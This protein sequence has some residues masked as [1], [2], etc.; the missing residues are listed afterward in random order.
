[1]PP[2]EAQRYRFAGFEVDVA[3]RELRRNGRRIPLQPQPF[4]LL[5]LLLENAG[6]VVTRE[7]IAERLWKDYQV[8]DPAQSLNVAVGKLRD[9]LNDRSAEPAF[10]ETVSKYGYR[11]LVAVDTDNATPAQ[12]AAPAEPV[13]R[14]RW[15]W[16]AAAAAAIVA[17]AAV[18]LLV[19]QPSVPDSPAPVIV[20]RFEDSTGEKDLEGAY[21][22]FLE[23]ELASSRFVSVASPDR[24]GDVL[25]LM[26]KDPSGRP[27]FEDAIEVCRRDPAIRAV[28]GGELR[29]AGA[30]YWLSLRLVNPASA[31]SMAALN[32]EA[33]ARPGLA[34]VLR[35]FSDAIRRRM[36]ESPPAQTV[37]L[38]KV[39]TRSLQAL[40]LFSDAH[41]LARSWNWRT[42]EVLFRQAADLDPE[43]A[44]AHLFVAWAI[45]NQKD[46]SAK[47]DYLP[48]AER[49]LALAANASEQEALF[50]RGSYYSLQLDQRSLEQSVPLYDL[51]LRRYPDHPWAFRNLSTTYSFL[52]QF[53]NRRVLQRSLLQL[54]PH[55]PETYWVNASRCLCDPDED[56][57]R[58]IEFAGRAVELTRESGADANVLQDALMDQQVLRAVA[59]WSR[60]EIREAKRELDQA[61]ASLEQ[62]ARTADD[63]GDDRATLWTAL[64]YITLGELRRGAEL[65][66]R[67]ER[68]ALGGLPRF[69]RLWAAVLADDRE[70]IAAFAADEYRL[71]PLPLFIIGLARGGHAETAAR[72][73]K[74][75]K[76][77]P[78]PDFLDES[79]SV[80]EAVLAVRNSQFDAAIPL[81]ERAL[82]TIPHSLSERFYGAQSLAHAYSAL[83]RPNDAIV[84]LETTTAASR[85]CGRFATG[86]SWLLARFDLMELYRETGRNR[87][88]DAIRRQLSN[89]LMYADDNHVLKKRL[90]AW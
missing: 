25:K 2:V 48:H 7:Q 32:G 37:A 6:R 64:G 78:D 61:A 22:L 53:G 40:K 27:R 29:R 36:G 83:G 26:R 75:R 63:G 87:E 72:V 90:G 31:Q 74:R 16:M 24:V 41:A 42:A 70:Q 51:L 34:P 55:H 84:A 17:L 56:P 89:L 69:W 79:Y 4:Q 18:A 80:A 68:P 49:A 58:V 19:R 38:D 82:A 76:P 67:I 20:A 23:N 5:S 9:A 71:N 3:A 59:H 14:T 86:F 65:L 62:R 85:V 8:A 45:F 60:D 57:D 15:M 77:A 46:V 12:E 11:F 28:I 73:L 88:A 13:P 47:A 39:T 21:E 1:M 30:K 44:S 50:I 43:F 54:R 10:I 35:Q 81:L 33:E 66:G 52:R